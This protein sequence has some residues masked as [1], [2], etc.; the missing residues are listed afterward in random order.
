MFFVIL[1]AVAKMSF[2][3]K[4]VEYNETIYWNSKPIIAEAQRKLQ[5]CPDTMCN[6]YTLGFSNQYTILKISFR[7]K[8][9]SVASRWTSQLVRNPKFT[10]ALRNY[11]YTCVNWEQ[12]IENTLCFVNSVEDLL[13]KFYDRRFTTSNL[14]VRQNRLDSNFKA[15]INQNFDNEVA[16]TLV[17][18][19]RLIPK[20][21]D[22]LLRKLPEV[23]DLVIN[24]EL[25]EDKTA[26]DR[27]V[28]IISDNQ[29][30]DI[31]PNFAENIFQVSRTCYKV[32]WLK[33]TF[34]LV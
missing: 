20:N 33:M 32:K 28:S 34:R 12:L 31:I 9:C 1:Q 15:L 29:A 18:T 19:C 6:R 25:Q 2:L 23:L 13:S 14:N 17:K 10:F 21:K 16:Q 22:F 5:G 11:Y 24:D 30:R 8:L 3:R 7:F 27:F 26:F 4:V